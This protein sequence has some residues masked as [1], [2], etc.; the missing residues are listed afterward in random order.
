[1]NCDDNFTEVSADRMADLSV[2]LD[3]AL[4]PVVVDNFITA[5]NDRDTLNKLC[6][7]HIELYL[8]YFLIR[9]N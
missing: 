3:R 1:M 4:T 2:N 5:E 9:T 7:I 6:K 8:R